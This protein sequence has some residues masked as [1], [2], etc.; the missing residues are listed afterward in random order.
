MKIKRLPVVF[1]V[2]GIAIKTLL[3]ILLRLT[4]SKGLLTLLTIYDPGAMY[5]ADRIT[6]L[7]FDNR[8]IPFATGVDT[9]FEICLV[10]GFGIECLLAGFLFRWLLGRVQG[11]RRGWRIHA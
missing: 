11:Q 3:L 2:T 9:L 8:S 4:G 5:F 1:L 7:F 10:I 6:R